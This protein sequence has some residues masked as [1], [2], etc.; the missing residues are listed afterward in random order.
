[1]RLGVCNSLPRILSVAAAFALLATGLPA[2]KK[3]VLQLQRDVQLLTLAQRELQRSVDEKHAVLKTLIEQQMDATSKLNTAISGL[4]KSMEDVQAN[5]GARIDTMSTQ[6]QALADNFEEVKV[7]LGRMSQQLSD[8]QAVIQS[9]DAKVAGG[10]PPMSSGSGAAPAP[11][12]GAA[13]S[14]PSAETLYSNA[15]RDFTGGKYDLSRQ[16]FEDYIRF[17]PESDLASNARFYIGEINYAEKKY[18]EAIRDYD[19]VLERYPRSFKL[20]DAR[21]KKALALL[22]IGQKSSAQR[23]LR[24]VISRHPG[25]EAERRARSALREISTPSGQ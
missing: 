8:A 4:Q 12:G 21:L 2:Q 23:E 11:G 16:E 14:A 19:Q 7:R 15:L 20:A 17:F 6:V 9:L 3:E 10:A 5:S 13:P 1:M 25:T 22:Q 24:E 18:A